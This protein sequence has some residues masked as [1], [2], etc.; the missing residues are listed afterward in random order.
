MPS[1]LC[2]SVTTGLPGCP[3]NSPWA[4][5]RP[6]SVNS[7]QQK[8]PGVECLWF[9]LVLFCF[10]STTCEIVISPSHRARCPAG[11]SARRLEAGPGR[12]ASSVLFLALCPAVQPQQMLKGMFL[13]MKNKSGCEFPSQS[14]GKMG[15]AGRAQR[16]LLGN[17]CGQ[18]SVGTEWQCRSLLPR[19]G[20]GFPPSVRVF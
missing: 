4:T 9:C 18:A 16:F 15:G 17:V 1:K 7:S 12:Q 19:K 8:G 20:G 6:R 14:L 10:V 3:P 2:L 13:K 5:S 11:R